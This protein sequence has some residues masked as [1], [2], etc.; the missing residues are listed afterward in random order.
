MYTF[1][2]VFL[3]IDFF[4]FCKLLNGQGECW[5]KA[6]LLDQCPYILAN[7]VAADPEVMELKSCGT[8]ML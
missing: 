4:F 1:H 8:A 3:K 5:H 7:E 2:L 6:G